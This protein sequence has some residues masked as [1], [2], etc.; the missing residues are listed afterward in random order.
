MTGKTQPDENLFAARLQD[1]FETVEQ[2]CIPK[3]TSYLDE[4]QVFLAQ[5]YL[6]HRHKE[7]WMLWGGYDHAQRQMLGV[8][9]D[10]LEPEEAAFPIAALTFRFRKED[11]LSHRDFL[12]SLMALQIKREA[13]GDILVSEGNCILFVTDKVEPLIC[14]EIT[15]IGRTGVKIEKG[16]TASLSREEQFREISGTVASLRLDCVVSLMTGKSREKACE[17]IR[18]GLVSL[19]HRETE[20]NSAAVE[21][22]DILSV[23]GFG[24]AKL[25]EQLRETK[26]GRIYITLLKYL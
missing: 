6:K 12:G 11:T 18:A 25:S 8:F 1:I 20:S 24:K 14:S 2:R 22:G 4:R 23:R 17:L 15:K 9:P 19:N 5:E 16:I 10:Y 7:N 13:V 26:K 21:T 3:F